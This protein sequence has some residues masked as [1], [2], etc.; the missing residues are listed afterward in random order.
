M[1]PHLNSVP[2]LKFACNEKGVVHINEEGDG[3]SISRL[4]RQREQKVEKR[5]RER[6]REDAIE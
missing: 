4:K 1:A 2:K 6:V 3:G 5:D